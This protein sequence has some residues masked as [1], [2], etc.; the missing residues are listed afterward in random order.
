M[1][2]QKDFLI[3]LFEVADREASTVEEAVGLLDLV[4]ALVPQLDQGLVVKDVLDVEGLFPVGLRR[5]EET[6]G[7]VGLPYFH[8]PL[9]RAN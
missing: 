7:S 5:E 4:E 8:L 3:D 6:L 1:L 9:L 2:I